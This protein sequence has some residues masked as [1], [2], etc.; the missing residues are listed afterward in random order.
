MSSTMKT[1]MINANNEVARSK[2]IGAMA[3]LLSLLVGTAAL[4]TPLHSVMAQNKPA[5]QPVLGGQASTAGASGPTQP[6]LGG[7]ASTA[8]PSL[9]T[10]FVEADGTLQ[11][12]IGAVSASQLQFPPGT[13]LP[14]QYEVVFNR[15]VRMG[16]YA[17]TLGPSFGFGILEPG[18]I[19]AAPSTPFGTVHPNGVFVLTR[20]VQGIP[21]SHGF[22]LTVVVP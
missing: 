18:S 11:Y 4:I 10:A 6:V 17:A 15:D 14:G 22:W 21:E 1:K 7:Q 3:A 5:T 20:D 12:G 2:P 19:N 13:L 9:V 16:V 8:A